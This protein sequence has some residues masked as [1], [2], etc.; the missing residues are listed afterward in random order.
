MNEEIKQQV[1]VELYELYDELV[2]K[3]PFNKLDSY[4]VLENTKHHREKKKNLLKIKEIKN[5]LILKLGYAPVFAVL[6]LASFLKSELSLNYSN[7]DKI[8]LLIYQLLC[9]ESLNQFGDNFM[10]SSSFKK[11]HNEFWEKNYTGN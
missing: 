11:L 2:S 3:F 1:N 7:V 8:L 4:P 5:E 9:K 6:S 10:N